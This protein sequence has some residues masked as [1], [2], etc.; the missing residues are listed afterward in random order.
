MT[1][2]EQAAIG[3][4]LSAIRDKVA[5]FKGSL[6][7]RSWK[8]PALTFEDREAAY[9]LANAIGEAIEREPGRVLFA[10]YQLTPREDGP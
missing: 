5:G 7:G 8:I 10:A 2:V 4:I 1:T 3:I 9:R 6:A